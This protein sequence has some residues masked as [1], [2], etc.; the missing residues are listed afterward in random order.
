MKW[1]TNFSFRKLFA[2]KKV[3]VSFSVVLAFIFWLIIVLD[4][5]PD[6]SRS[7][8]DVPIAINTASLEKMGLTI[9]SKDYKD[10]VEVSVNGPGY[11]V[12][13]LSVDD[14]AIVADL[15]RI[16][17]PGTHQV[18]LIARKVGSKTD[19]EIVSVSLDSIIIHV[20]KVREKYVPVEAESPNITL[21]LEFDR[22]LIRGETILSEERIHI[23]GPEE[24][25]EKV[26]SAKAFVDAE[27]ALRTDST[28]EGKIKL[29]NAEGNEIDP[30]PFVFTKTIN[31]TYK[32]LKN[33][34]VNIK[35][36]FNKKPVNAPD[37]P[38]TIKL[39]T[40]DKI[41]TIDV[42]GPP[43]IIN[44]LTEIQLEPVDFYEITANKSFEV[45]F[46]LPS[47]S[48]K[49]IDQTDKVNLAFDLSDYRTKP[50]YSVPIEV[51]NA[52]GEYTIT[53][54]S[55]SAITL[56][57]HK[58]YYRN[59]KVSDIKAVVDLRD[60]SPDHTVKV[61]FSSDKCIVW[62]TKECVVTYKATN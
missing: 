30:S 9:T 28:F 23:E 2:N 21:D 16:N 8:S 5:N 4:Q 53:P 57:V 43:E 19:F 40:G 13:A 50:F 24:A 59:L 61:S 3:A 48:V 44:T 35:P 1:L 46:L 39:P 10:T 37:L 11:V 41:T 58:D 52:K 20:D 55:Y 49:I 62:E 15:S 32:V 38:F 56:F 34:K 54:S 22:N 25:L 51:I 42:Q 7:F 18:D 29:Y 60:A 17:S 26:V 36:S 33:A 12:S 27:A 14:I 31:V 47:D 45:G 6:M